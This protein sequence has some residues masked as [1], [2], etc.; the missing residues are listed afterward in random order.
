MK[1]K[2]RRLTVGTVLAAALA[3]GA[4]FYAT[5]HRQPAAA[6]VANAQKGSTS[7]TS[8][9]SAGGQGLHHYDGPTVN[10]YYG[11]VKVQAVVDHG[12]LK[13]VVVLK[14]PNDNGTSRYINSVAMP[15]LV[16]EAVKSQS[17]NIQLI[18][19]ATFSSEAFVKS[20]SSALS[21]AGV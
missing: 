6:S 4:V 18:S 20:L 10:A 12:K 2:A 11:Y 21:Q 3:I 7:G 1:V 5:R 14:H 9:K 17:A 13:K 15:Y 8:T 16:K 19:G